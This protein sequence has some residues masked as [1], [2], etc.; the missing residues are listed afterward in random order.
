MP[1]APAPTTTIVLGSS[2]Q[3]P[4]LLGADHAAAELRARDRLLDRAGG[5]DDALR[6]VDLVAVEVAE[7][8]LTLPSPV[9]APWPSMTSISF[10]LN[11]PPTPPVSVLTTFGAARR[12]GVEVDLGLGD[13]DAELVGVA[14]LVEHVG[15]AQHGLGGDAGVVQAAPADD[16]LLDDGGLHA[17]LGGA[18]RGDVAARARSR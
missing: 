14:D 13:L 10:F 3:R 9:T 7:P 4:R 6:R 5:E 1:D 18:D 8:T 12:D 16:V 2:V 17:Q 15:H 11:S